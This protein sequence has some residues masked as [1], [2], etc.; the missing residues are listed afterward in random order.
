MSATSDFLRT[1]VRTVPDWPA[2]GVQFRDITPLLQ[3]AAVFRVLVEAF[4]QRYRATSRRPGVVAGLDARGFI[5]GAVLAYQLDVGF[6]PIRKK[7]KLPFTTVQETYELE[8]GSA[9]VELHTDAVR[10]GD[11]VLLVDDLIATGGTMMAGKKL[12]EKLG[13]HVTEGAAIVDL[14]ELGGS[15]RLRAS[16]LPLFTLLD[17]AGH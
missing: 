7:G 9:T 5:L 17:F 16:G 12:L 3:D 11:Q 13:A 8:Y 6:V 14:P 10:P 2:P 15:A 4:V 1:H